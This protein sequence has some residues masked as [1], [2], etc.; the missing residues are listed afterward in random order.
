[1]QYMKIW[2]SVVRKITKNSSQN[3]NS[4]I[5]VHIFN[6]Y[7]AEGTSDDCKKYVKVFANLLSYSGISLIDLLLSF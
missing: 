7:L 4:Q 2:A 3:M 6:L 1:M 5:L